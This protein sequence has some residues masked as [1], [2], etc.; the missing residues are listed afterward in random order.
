MRFKSRTMLTA[1]IAA[2]S[3]TAVTAAPAL[4]S[5]K[6]SVETKPATTIGETTATLNGVVNPNGAE[7]KYYFEYGHTTS[8]GKKTAEVAV[9]S[10]T[11]NLEESKEAIHMIANSE[12]HFRIVAV[13]TN[14][15]SDG[16]DEVFVT[17]AKKGLPEIE[18]PAGKFPVKFTFS[19]NEVEFQPKNTG[20]VSLSCTGQ[21]GAGEITGPKRLMFKE[22]K[23]TGCRAGGGGNPACHTKGAA[24]GEVVAEP[25]TEAHLAYVAKEGKKQEEV[26]FVLN[27][28]P[29]GNGMFTSEIECTGPGDYGRFVS[30]LVAPIKGI[31]NGTQTISFDLGYSQIEGLQVPDEYESEAGGMVTTQFLL[32]VTGKEIDYGFAGAEEKFSVEKEIRFRY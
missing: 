11:S 9:G 22:Y 10:G 27:T 6:P 4:A 5:G 24:S 26:A 8:Y 23:L 12:Y 1:L 31:A 29:S 15:T 3:V 20:F 16:A 14:G 25:N 2:L 19:S 7:T 17:T 13:N 28:T 32:D 21:K 30:A 18:G